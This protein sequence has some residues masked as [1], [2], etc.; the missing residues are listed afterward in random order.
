MPLILFGNASRPSHNLHAPLGALPHQ[1]EGPAAVFRKFAVAK[2]VG[3][4]RTLMLKDGMTTSR[5]KPKPS[6]PRAAPVS[7]A[8]FADEVERAQWPVIKRKVE[9]ALASIAKGKGRKWDLDRFLAEAEKRRRSKL[10][11]E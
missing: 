7:D 10:A 3:A 5:K 4:L 1:H 2:H 9:A 8:K 6:R 11:A